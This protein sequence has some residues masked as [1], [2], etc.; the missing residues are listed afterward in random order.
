V[1]CQGK[2]PTTVVTYSIQ[3]TRCLQATR[4]GTGF[5]QVLRYNLGSLAELG[6]SP[7]D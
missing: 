4:D 5:Q 1:R 6:T 2:Y 7:V 3:G